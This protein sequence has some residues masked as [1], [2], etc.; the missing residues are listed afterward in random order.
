MV[1]SATSADPS[2]APRGA[3]N[4]PPLRVGRK[5]HV[6]SGT[7]AGEVGEI[8]SVHNKTCKLKIR[9]DT[10][11]YLPKDILELPVPQP[12]AK[13]DPQTQTAAASSDFEVGQEVRV[14]VGNYEGQEGEVHSV[15]DKTCRLRIGDDVTGYLSKDNLEA[16]TPQSPDRRQKLVKVEDPDSPGGVADFPPPP[17]AE[18]QAYV[19]FEVDQKVRVTGGNYEGQEGEVHSVH[20]KTCRL[21]IGNDV[22][23]YLSKDILEVLVESTAQHPPPPKTLEDE[24]EEEALAAVLLGCNYGGKTRKEQE[25]E[26]KAAEEVGIEVRSAAGALG[27]VLGD[28]VCVVRTL[29][30]LKLPTKNIV[31]FV[32]KDNTKSLYVSPRKHS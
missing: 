24:K 29:R 19:A 1:I 7:Y 2:R 22:T 21:W 16:A 6:S 23:G 30:A 10:T 11:G 27:E 12:K 20:E 32:N 18:P 3:P 13:A 28:I 17:K 4:K 31:R 26:E 5:V 9:D 25:E 14:T 8:I 15:H